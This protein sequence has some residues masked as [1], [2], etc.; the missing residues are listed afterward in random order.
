[1]SNQL[2]RQALVAEIERA[3]VAW[4]AANPTS[5]ILVDYENQEQINLSGAALYLMVDVVFRDSAQVDLNPAANIR[6][7]GQ[8]MIAAGSKEGMGT[9]QAE[10]L[11]D[12]MRPYLH[13]RDDL[14][15]GVRTEV[16]KVYPPKSNRGFYYL[17][18]VAGF[19]RIAPKPVTP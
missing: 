4:N 1:M 15:N 11:R 10:R 17:P 3:K 16:A 2:V 9:Q 19:W 12:F 14:A 18:L 6:D 5:Q 13:M 8:V 7:T